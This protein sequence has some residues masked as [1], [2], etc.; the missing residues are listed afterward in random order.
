MQLV[1][2]GPRSERPATRIGHR[3]ESF[4][5]CDPTLPSSALAHTSC[6]LQK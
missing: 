4:V 3:I 1:T 5:R 2:E 6:C